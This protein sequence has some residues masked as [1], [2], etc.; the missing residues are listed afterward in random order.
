MEMTDFYEPRLNSE[1]KS[2]QETDLFTLIKKSFLGD[3]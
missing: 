3:L 1:N 2:T